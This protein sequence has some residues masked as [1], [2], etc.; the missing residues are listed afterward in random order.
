[1]S[2]FSP[3]SATVT[4]PAPHTWPLGTVA[5]LCWEW[6]ANG[7]TD[8]SPLQTRVRQACNP[9]RRKKVR[10]PGER[11]SCGF[12]T[13]LNQPCSYTRTS[14]V[15][16]FRVEKDKQDGISPVK[17]LLK[18]LEAI[19]LMTRTGRRPFCG[20]ASGSKIGGAG[21]SD[22]GGREVRLTRP[23]LSKALTE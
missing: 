17:P 4:Q 7:M 23:W 10:C 15:P 22:H 6:E 19:R 2:L 13:R 11:P 20:W 1:M 18:R 12:C 14:L 5:C 21:G 16:G 9:C 3:V 8:S